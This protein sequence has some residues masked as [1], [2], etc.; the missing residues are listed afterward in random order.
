MIFD[1]DGTLIDSEPVF[2]A[3][4]KRTAIEFDQCFTDE[5]YLDLIGLPNSEVERGILAAFGQDF[6]LHDFRISFEKHWMEH[7]KANGIALKHGALN[8]LDQL[9]DRA[10]PYAIATSTS[11]IRAR[12]ALRLAGLDGRFEHLIGGDQV[13]NG[14]PAADIYLR[15]ATAISTLPSRCVA[16]EDSNVGVHAAAAANMHTIIIPDLKPPD[17][18]TLT[19]AAGVFPS[20]GEATPHIL[21]LLTMCTNSNS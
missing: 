2:K 18:Q 20:L 10:V 11:H 9:D 14:K 21:N 19:L 15:A 1:L 3:V 7:V 8:L 4:S 13:D 17:A 5:L 16:I 6:P 12:H